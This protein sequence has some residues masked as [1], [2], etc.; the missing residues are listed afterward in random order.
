VDVKLVMQEDKRYYVGKIR[1]TGNE[2]TRDK[3][4]RREIYLDEG[5]VFNTEALKLS[6]KRINQLG[7]FK[8]I[9][10]MPDL[11]AS[12]L[13]EDKV[14]V[15]FKV[16][17]ENRNQFTLGGGVSGY[18]GTFVN[19][20]FSTSNFLG[21][22]ETLQLSAQTGTRIKNYQFAVTEPYFLDRP[23]TAG[24]D[25]YHRRV[26]YYG[27]SSST[28]YADQ[29]TGGTLTAGIPVSRFT[30]LYTSYTYEVVNIQKANLKDLTYYELASGSVASSLYL[31]DELGKRKESRIAPSLVRNTVDN[32]YMP[33][34]G[35]RVSLTLQV[36]GGPLQGSMNYFSPNAEI[37]Y[38]LPH[39]KRTALGLRLDTGWIKPFGKTARIRPPDDTY[40]YS[41]DG[42]PFYHRFALGGEN[43][44]RGY[45]YYSIFPAV[46]D[47][48]MVRGDKFAVF[49]AEYYVDIYGPLRVLAFFDAGAVYRD[50]DRIDPKLIR[51]STGLEG[52]FTM[53]VMNV[54]FRVIYAINPNRSA[55]HIKDWGVKRYELK[56]SVGTTF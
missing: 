30:R 36:A 9:E 54:P 19:S 39:T 10:E 50:S 5:A 27:G 45:P 7:Y 22:G 2:T 55:T 13:G 46:K 38:Y 48:R 16:K 35:S 56:F 8:Q 6:I 29:R 43:Q 24:F 25:L 21:A 1:F 14:D 32:P 3:V 18:E 31:Y 4:V 49:N 47:G 51:M 11:A 40:S 28:G 42:L 12:S 44:V 23:I 15:T 53:P 20:S 33:H 41:R 26:V 37:I 34:S 17:E 52:R